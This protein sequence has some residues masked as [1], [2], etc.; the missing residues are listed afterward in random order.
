MTELPSFMKH[1]N[2]SVINGFMVAST[3]TDRK[4]GTVNILHPGDEAYQ[5]IW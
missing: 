1:G 2:K 3:K 4:L 5:N